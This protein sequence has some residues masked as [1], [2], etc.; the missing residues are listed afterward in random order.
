MDSVPLEIHR[1]KKWVY[2]PISKGTALLIFTALGKM[3][4]ERPV[5]VSKPADL[6]RF[7]VAHP[8]FCGNDLLD[9]AT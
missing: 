3:K 4:T 7:S 6:S 5:A 2:R 9:R 1:A 8:A